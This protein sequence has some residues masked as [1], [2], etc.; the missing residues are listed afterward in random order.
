MV[1]FRV[2][3]LSDNFNPN[4]VVEKLVV[5][6]PGVVLQFSVCRVFKNETKGLKHVTHMSTTLG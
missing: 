2:T 3:L 1:E 4:V 6:H 5:L